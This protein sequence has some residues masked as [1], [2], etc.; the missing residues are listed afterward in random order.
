MVFPIFFA[1]HYTGVVDEDGEMG[2]VAVEL[3]VVVARQA[4]QVA[5]YD[6]SKPQIGMKRLPVVVSNGLNDRQQGRIEL[7]RLTRNDQQRY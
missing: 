5:C 7:T 3:L 2:V 4:R 6:V 1:G